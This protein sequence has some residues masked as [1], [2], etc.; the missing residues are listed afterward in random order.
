MKTL[1]LTLFLICGFL[2]GLVAAD[3][4]YVP[5]NNPTQGG[6]NN[7]PWNANTSSEWRF[8][9]LYTAQQMQNK[10]GIIN[11]IAF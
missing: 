7:W 6:K 5:S 11:A 10:A 4:I 1:T 8:Q 3:E 2:A 9:Q